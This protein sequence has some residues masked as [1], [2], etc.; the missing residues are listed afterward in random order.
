MIIVY[1]GFVSKNHLLKS[2]TTEE[3]HT[4]VSIVTKTESCSIHT[5]LYVPKVFGSLIKN[6]KSIFQNSK[7]RTIFLKCIIF[8]ENLSIGSFQ[9]RCLR[10]WRSFNIQNGVSNMVDGFFK[11]PLNSNSYCQQSQTQPDVIKLGV[12]SWKRIFSVNV[13]ANYKG[14]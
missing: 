4:K 14:F 11:N 10:N 7:W 1:C 2:L 3:I 9:G 12:V 13:S 8:A 6:L 5:N